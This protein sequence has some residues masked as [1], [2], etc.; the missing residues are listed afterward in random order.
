MAL[1]LREFRASGYRSLRS[2]AYPVSGLEVFVGANGVGKTNIYRALELVRSAAANTLGSDLAQEGMGSAMW[3]GSHPRNSPI[4]MGFSVGLAESGKDRPSYSY[5]VTVGFPPR[6]AAPAFAQEPQV[7]EETLT[8]L[9]GRRPVQLMHRK[10]HSLTVRDE[11]GRVV[12]VDADLLASETALG[13]LE[14]PSRYPDLELV[15]RTLLQWRFYHDLRTDAASPLRR[16]CPAVATPMLASDGSNLAAV[17][18]T[19]AYIRED[20][21]ELD[22]AVEAAFPGASLVVE[23]PSGRDVGF[24]LR[25]PEF[26][27]REF[28]AAELSDGTLR[29]LALAGALLSYRLPP[30]IALNEPEASL[31]PALMEPLAR[32]VVQAARRSQVLL[33]THSESLARAIAELGA[34]KVRTVQKREGATEIAGLSRWGEFHDEDDE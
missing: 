3:A 18:A 29:Y 20:T 5:D 25:F 13:R 10:G 14:D 28:D 8:F 19:L 9:S 17:L 33:V 22:A 21:S 27:N 4:Q 2:I 7:K 11:A 1:E 12:E 34:A 23:D 30:F 16:P 26:P 6:V 31:H 24:R 32:L 15:R